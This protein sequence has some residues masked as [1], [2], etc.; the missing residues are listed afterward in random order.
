[1]CSRRYPARRAST[2]SCAPWPAAS[3]A[4]PRSRR[5]RASRAES[6]GRKAFI[7][8]PAC[9]ATSGQRSNLPGLLEAGERLGGKV[10]VGGELLLGNALREVA[11]LAH[12][13]MDAPGSIEQMQR[14]RVRHH[15]AHE[16]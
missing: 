13:A 2:T 7:C 15:L 16:E 11:V 8:V 3:I 5:T 10:Q 14:D 9:P 6:C 1:M 12:E 4:F